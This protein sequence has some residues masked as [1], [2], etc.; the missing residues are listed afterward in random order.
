MRQNH[1]SH[2]RDVV[3]RQK[4]LFIS[5]PYYCYLHANH[6]YILFRILGALF[7]SGSSFF[8]FFLCS[9][10]VKMGKFGDTYSGV[11]THLGMSD[12]SFFF[13]HVVPLVLYLKMLGFFTLEP[14][15]I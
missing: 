11:I 15:I 9:I 8:F 5:H 10:I 1:S 4:I 2:V 12:K 6:F 7:E 13:Q 3:H 14:P